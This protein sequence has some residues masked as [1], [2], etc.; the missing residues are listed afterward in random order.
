M[1]MKGRSCLGLL[2]L[3][4]V[5]ACAPARSGG[6]AS[7]AAPAAA[8][9]QPPAAQAP[10]G[11]EWERL[12]AGAQQEGRLV[13]SG[14]P[15][16]SWRAA[17][18][19]FQTDY[20]GIT[21]DYTGFNSRDFYPRLRQERQAG[22]N[23][24][25][26]RVGG[27]A[28]L[29]FD[30]KNDGLTDPVRPLLILPEVTRPDAWLGGF[31]KIF[32]DKEGVYVPA[33]LAYEL[34][35]I[36]ANRDLAPEAEVSSSE[37]LTDPRWKGQIVVQDPRGGSGL[38]T[39]ASFLKAYG[40]DWVRDLLTKQ[41]AV[42]TSD[43]RQQA[44]WVVRGRYPIAVGFDTA[45]LAEYQRQGVGLNVKPVERGVKR[46]TNGFG[47]IHVIQGRPHPQAT[48]LFVNWLL[49]RAVQE[50]LT[51]ITQLNSAR[52]DV[53][54]GNPELVIDPAT[55]DQYLNVSQEE[56]RSLVEQTERLS[57]ELVK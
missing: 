52:L 21:V 19:S 9:A 55:L 4:L 6:G 43:N 7:G 20:P 44:D 37:Q 2:A 39:L 53:R 45:L 32:L 47:A 16:D 33:F 13:V 30:A 54:P 5:A 56:Y 41:D 11:A 22:L 36:Y 27:A 50:R 3:L 12:V 17:L 28:S 8:P 14:A 15:G 34:K 23:A 48:Q 25:D 38:V 1:P 51:E 31:D 10:T 29:E 57:R 46:W 40:E 24:W 42:V 26:V 18:T 35:G 49:T